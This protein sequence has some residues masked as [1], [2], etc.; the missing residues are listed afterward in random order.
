MN[1]AIQMNYVNT[2]KNHFKR[3]PVLAKYGHRVMKSLWSI[4]AV[5]KDYHYPSDNSATISYDLV[6][7]FNKNRIFGP[8]AKIC[9]AAF[10][11]MHFQ[12]NGDVTSCSFNYDVCLGNIL[13]KSIKEIWFGEN[14]RKFRED[15]SNYNL[16]K[17]MSC[18]KV[19][20]S[21]NF[22]SFPALKYDMYSNDETQFPT[23]MSFET[24]DLCNYAC[25]MCNENFSSAIKKDKGLPRIKSIYPRDFTH[26][27]QEFIPHLKIATFIGGEPLLIKEY[28]DIW[29]SILKN[30]KNCKIHIQSNGSIILPKFIRFIES[31]QFDIGISLDSV[32][33]S[34]FEKIRVHSNFDDVLNNIYRLKEFEKAGKISMNFNF[35]PLTLN[36]NELPELVEFSNKLNISLKIVHV[37]NPFHLGLPHRD[38]TYLTNIYNTLEKTVLKENNS[39]VARL[40]KEV[41]LGY[42]NNI[43]FY[44]EESRKRE[45]IILDYRNK[46]IDDL[47][48]LVKKTIQSNK[49][50]IHFNIEQKQKIYE[51]IVEEFSALTLRSRTFIICRLLFYFNEADIE[52][53]S[54]MAT[55]FDTG[56]R[57][58]KNII[59]QLNLLSEETDM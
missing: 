22:N 59:T 20:L 9:Y 53:S 58:L 32:N 11:N 35:C 48:N 27:L 14:A 17:C 10:N 50:F 34:T 47:M 21:K 23:Q 43:R 29:E 16:D 42:L 12:M 41:Y 13:T 4:Q 2:L 54:S 44:I 5:I 46:G 39:L 8:K 45:A 28:Y 18:K 31:G 7:E 15:M 25:I 49:K 52:G 33:K 6:K 3:Y 24:S 55:D 26:Q 57:T 56:I 19:L 1:S 36:W 40:N 30:N 38:A 37:T 51:C